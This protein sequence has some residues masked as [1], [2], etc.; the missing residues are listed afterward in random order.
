MVAFLLKLNLNVENNRILCGVKMDL[1]KEN[2]QVKEY[3]LSILFAPKIVK[4]SG[5]FSRAF[6]LITFIYHGLIK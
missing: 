5:S 1:T 2:A 4:S 3:D 6:L